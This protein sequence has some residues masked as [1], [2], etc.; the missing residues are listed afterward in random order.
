ML[1]ALTSLDFPIMKEFEKAPILISL[2]RELRLE[3]H[4]SAIQSGADH[5]CHSDASDHLFKPLVHQRHT[6]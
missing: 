6:P 4:I 5:P 2:G 1:A 3:P